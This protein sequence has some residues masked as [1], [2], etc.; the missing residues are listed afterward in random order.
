MIKSRNPNQASEAEKG[1]A[2]NEQLW[3]EL[4]PQQASLVHGGGL[5]AI[6]ITGFRVRGG[7]L[8]ASLTVGLR[9]RDGTDPFDLPPT[10]I[11]VAS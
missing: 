1:N 5:M 3:Q 4:S 2:Q 10:Q 8:L 9:L 7:E 6:P 11:N